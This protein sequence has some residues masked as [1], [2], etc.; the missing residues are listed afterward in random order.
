MLTFPNQPWPISFKYRRL[1][2]PR[3]VDLRSCTR[4]E[5][6]ARNCLATAPLPGPSGRRER[7]QA[8]QPSGGRLEGCHQGQCLLAL[9]W[10]LSAEPGDSISPRA[11]L[12]KGAQ[13]RGEKPSPDSS[14]WK[15]VWVRREAATEARRQQSSR[16]PT[17]A[18]GWHPN[19]HHT[20]AAF[21]GG[22]LAQPCTGHTGSFLP[23][24]QAE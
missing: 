23:V 21:V 12:G 5:Q 24:G 17:P 20:K 15:A 3:S 14:I 13:S 11:S 19:T 22:C 6:R 18:T 10:L 16:P 8:A 9:R 1:C 2:R 7:P 4:V